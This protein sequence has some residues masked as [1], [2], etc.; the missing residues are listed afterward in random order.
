MAEKKKAVFGECV[1]CQGPIV[2]DVVREYDPMRGP[3][4]IGPGSRQQFH[5]VTKGFYCDDCGVYYHHVPKK[6]AGV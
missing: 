2:K 3:P 6:K 5:S 4:V 1:V